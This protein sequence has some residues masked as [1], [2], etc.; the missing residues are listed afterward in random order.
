MSIQFNDNENENLV[1]EMK[2]LIKIFRRRGRDVSK[3]LL[4][5]LLLKVNSKK[6]TKMSQY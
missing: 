5:N 3:D 2:F 6:F 1:Y 4:L